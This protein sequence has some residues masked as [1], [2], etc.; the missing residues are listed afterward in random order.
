MVADGGVW[1]RQQQQQLPLSSLS[2]SIRLID[3]SASQAAGY[4]Q[5]LIK[6]LSSSP[7]VRQTPSL[8]PSCSDVDL[9]PSGPALWACGGRDYCWCFPAI[10]LLSREPSVSGRRR[11]MGR[12]RTETS[13]QTPS[14]LIWRLHP[15]R[16]WKLSVWR[17]G[18]SEI[19]TW[20]ITMTPNSQQTQ[21]RGGW[22]HI[23]EH[24]RKE[25]IRNVWKETWTCFGYRIKWSC[26]QNFSR[27]CN[28]DL[29]QARWKQ[30]N[31]TKANHTRQQEE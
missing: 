20:Q 23:S 30:R 9:S 10:D 15:R 13:T 28:S 14:G 19:N 26:H 22:I 12:V 7:S 17:D 11:R 5:T 25:N 21:R 29:Q 18:E 3:G 8:L 6:A 2:E 31:E 16:K 24:L 4:V 27:L 1:G